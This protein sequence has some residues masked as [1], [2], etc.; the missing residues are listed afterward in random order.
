[1]LTNVTKDRRNLRKRGKRLIVKIIFKLFSNMTDGYK[2][3]TIMGGGMGSFMQAASKRLGIHW[4]RAH[5][6]V[7]G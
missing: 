5:V 7:S 2:K 6:E 3:T 1:M 4:P